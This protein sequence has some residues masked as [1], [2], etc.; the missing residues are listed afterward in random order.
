MSSSRTAD[1]ETVRKVNQSLVLGLIRSYAPIS[2]A[3]LASETGLNRST[4]S[5]IVTRLIEEGLVMETELLDSKVGRPGIALDLNPAG[6]AVIGMEIGV[7]FLSTIVTDFSSRTLWQDWCE[8]DTTLPQDEVIKRAEAKIEQALDVVNAHGLRPLGIGLGVPGIVDV[9]KGELLIAPNLGWK[10]VPIKSMWNDRFRIPVLV[11]NEANLAALGEYYFGVARYVDHF[12]F[13][14]ANVGLGGGIIVKGELFQGGN[15]FA[16][17]IGHIH[18][19]PNGEQC[20][21][22]RKGCWETQVGPIAVIR[23]VRKM[24]ETQNNNAVMKL[25]SGNLDALTFGMILDAARQKDPLCLKAVEDIAINLGT[26]IV[27][28]AHILDPELVV[29]GG[30]F[31]AA[32]DI[33]EPIITNIFLTEALPPSR[34]NLQIV[35]SEHGTDAPVFGAIAVVLDNII[36][37]PV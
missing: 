32:K 17:E 10:N 16:G 11:D 29:I 14:S 30:A 28:L 23:R 20:R 18:R 24:L 7:G 36:R 37:E 34:E 27:D 15:G 9:H 33:I 22:G 6:G 12:I 13:L 26:G 21:C 4:V 3:D 8:E 1:Q 35:F 31:S 19:D 2:R 5:S 25:C